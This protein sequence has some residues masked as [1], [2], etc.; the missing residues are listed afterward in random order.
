MKGYISTIGVLNGLN[1][2]PD[3]PRVTHSDQEK[4]NLRKLFL[5]H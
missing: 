1:A 3:L 4:L 5:V 2:R